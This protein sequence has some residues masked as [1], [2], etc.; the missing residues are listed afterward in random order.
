VNNLLQSLRIRWKLV[1]IFALPALALLS[2]AASSILSDASDLAG[3]RRERQVL[4]VAIDISRLA[5]EL[6]QE[7]TVS[8]LY[9]G[10][11]RREGLETLRRQRTRVDEGV[12]R[13]AESVGD[14]AETI[15]EPQVR[16]SLSAARTRLGELAPQRTA[17]DQAAP[18]LAEVSN[19]YTDRVNELLQVGAQ[20]ASEGGDP[21]VLRSASTLIAL[22]QMK[23]AMSLDRDLV[24]T[25]LYTGEVGNSVN[26]GM[27]LARSTEEVWRRR[28][29]ATASEPEWH[30]FAA[31]SD[32]R[33]IAQSDRLRQIV[34][35]AGRQGQVAAQASD[36]VIAAG[37]ELD[38]LR[39]TEDQVAGN[40]LAANQAV[41]SGHMRQL[42]NT[43]IIILVVIGLALASAALMARSMVRPLARLRDT[44]GDVARNQ[45]PGVVE[46]LQHAERVDPAVAD[47]EPIGI[48]SRDEIGEV[49]RAFDSAHTAAM[50]VTAGQ[51]ALRK[52]IGDMYL[53]LARR[54]QSLIDRQIE[55]IDELE[56]EEHDPDALEELFRLD[57][58]ATRLRRNAEDLIVLSGARP[59]RRWRQPV[60]LYDVI[61]AAAA[62]VEDYRR[63]ELLPMDDVGVSGQAVADVIHLLAELVE[64]ATSFSPPGTKVHVAGQHTPDGYLVEIEDRGVG[65]SNEELVEANHRLADPPMVDVSLSRRLG[66]FVVG[67]LA[68]RYDIRVELRHSWYG[69]VT[70]LVLLPGNLLARPGG[71][72]APA[73]V[74]ADRVGA[75]RRNPLEQGT[76][77]GGRNIYV[78]LRRHAGNSMGD[79]SGSIPWPRPPARTSLS[80]AGAS[81]PRSG[82]FGSSQGGRSVFGGAA[83]GPPPAPLAGLHRTAAGASPFETPQAFG[84]TPPRGTP[85]GPM[86]DGAG[87]TGPGAAGMPAPAGAPQAYGTTPPS[88]TPSA[89]R[90]GGPGAGPVPAGDPSS[91]TTRSPSGTPPEGGIPSGPPP[92]A[93]GAWQGS[94]GAPPSGAT[95]DTADATGPPDTGQ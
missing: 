41:G 93:P 58:L 92:G 59:T 40:L 16:T 31:L 3:V 34:V 20:V 38:A 69:G 78:P 11:Q 15:T 29:L 91:G 73:S 76:R 62:E 84:T 95:P 43:G 66:L 21:D 26:E 18:T 42:L 49:A 67:R 47:I 54:S 79:I 65:M 60:A 14:P 32:R 87:V 50:R 64:N 46:R 51:A 39:G 28:F 61:R 85:P 77:D 17:I 56:R 80:S 72:S 9:T 5:H 53:N 82:G 1:A 55:F 23:A 75:T 74:G 37:V 6:E 13:L 57:H 12:T 36:Y 90:P 8:L 68:R 89:P 7:R 27:D 4:T 22:G 94:P 52:S 48:E 63:I 71:V 45:L 88:G 44:A 25:A 24:L 19:F 86:T 33:D 35:A 30:A 83:E 10:S 81:A 70:A 2:V